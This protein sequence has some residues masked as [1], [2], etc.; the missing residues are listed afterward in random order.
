MKLSK[1][2][3][4][5]KRSKYA[6]DLEKYKFNHDQLMKKYE[7]EGVNIRKIMGSHKRQKE[8]LKRLKKLIPEKNFIYREKL[9]KELVKKSD[10]II[11]YGGDGHFGFVSHFIDNTN[12]LGINSDTKTSEG[13]LTY[14][15]IDSFE[16]NLKKILNEDFKIEEWTRLE[17]KRNDKKI[18]L[19]TS[20]IFLGEVE[21][22]FMSRHIIKHRNKKEEQKCSGIIISTGTGSTGWYTSASRY[23]FKKP[24]NFPRTA[25]YA[26]F[27]VTEPYKGR[28]NGYSMLTGTLN[29]EEEIII[30]SLNNTKGIV[31]LDSI[32]EYEFNRG[33]K[34]TIKIGKP[35]RIIR[36]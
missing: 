28:L 6:L 2:I 19:A 12:F 29:Q 10:L 4:V 25:K 30:T 8:G 34:I 21:R 32:E 27:L 35:L 15:D 36:I 9:T 22:K 1:I 23:L 5:P 17:V 11:A 18:G 3:V 31:S 13:I 14:F 16:K 24:N 7:R 33:T 26:R 20:D